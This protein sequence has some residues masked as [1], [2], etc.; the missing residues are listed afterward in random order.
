M[1]AIAAES[2]IEWIACVGDLRK[3]DRCSDVPD[4]GSVVFV[5]RKDGE[6]V[7]SEHSRSKTVYADRADFPDVTV[8]SGHLSAFVE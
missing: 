2:L 4:V 1:Y 8:S 7:M 3:S 6:A 5:G